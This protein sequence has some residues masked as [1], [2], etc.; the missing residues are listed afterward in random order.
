[1]LLTAQADSTLRMLAPLLE[2][3]DLATWN[4]KTHMSPAEVGAIEA[5]V[6][7]HLDRMQAPLAVLSERAMERL[8]P[9][10]LAPVADDIAIVERDLASAL[11]R[12]HVATVTHAQH[13]AHP[14]GCDHDNF[15]MRQ[16]VEYIRD[17]RATLGVIEGTLQLFGITDTQ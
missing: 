1:V 17:A 13:V 3:Q 16:A 6:E 9:H 12:L 10:V 7:E 4:G 5:G 8:E 14:G 11:E 15:P 2:G